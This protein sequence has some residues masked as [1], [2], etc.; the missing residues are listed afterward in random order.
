MNHIAAISSRM[1]TFGIA[2]VK[3]DSNIEA[4]AT[5]GV[6]LPEHWRRSIP[7]SDQ[8]IQPLL[9]SWSTL[10]YASPLAIHALHVHTNRS[11][12]IPTAS[13]VK[14]LGA[15]CSGLYVALVERDDE[16]LEF[17]ISEE[18]W[19]ISLRGALSLPLL[20]RVASIACGKTHVL[21]L[22]ADGELFAQGSNNFGQLGIGTIESSSGFVRLETLR[23]HRITQIACGGW[24]SVVAAGN[25]A[26]SFGSN[27][28][29]QLGLFISFLAFPMDDLGL[30]IPS[31]FFPI[32]RNEA[33]VGIPLILF[34]AEC[35][36]SITMFLVCISFS[37]FHSTGDDCL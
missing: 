28:H 6:E 36:I 8:I 18:P 29:G 26:F 30:I 5:E 2:F 24:H 3:K 7:C 19:T 31:F 27:R 22:S 21:S 15:S 4:R 12:L 32:C 1:S 14:A 37:L 34:C 13:D 35:L 33:P 10:F 17:E 16:V 25:V 23:Q 11:N 9:C 20:T